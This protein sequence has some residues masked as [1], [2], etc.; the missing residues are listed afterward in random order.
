VKASL[1]DVKA[2]ITHVAEVQRTK[3]KYCDL[4][5]EEMQKSVRHALSAANLKWQY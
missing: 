5:R 2:R 3:K 4:E 1:D